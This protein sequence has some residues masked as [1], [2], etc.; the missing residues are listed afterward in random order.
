MPLP[1]YLDPQGCEGSRNRQE[2]ILAWVLKMARVHPNVSE[3]DVGVWLV[4]RVDQTSLL[5]AFYWKTATG[6]CLQPKKKK[7]KGTSLSH[8][9]SGPFLSDNSGDPDLL[10]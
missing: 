1:C 6:T 4:G 3:R 2:C 10:Y 8:S 9:Y 5:S 7:K